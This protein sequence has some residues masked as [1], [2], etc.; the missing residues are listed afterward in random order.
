MTNSS[1]LWGHL[2]KKADF[3]SKEW[4]PPQSRFNTDK[5]TS[6]IKYGIGT[7]AFVFLLF[8]YNPFVKGLDV[9]LESLR[10][11]YKI[12]KEIT[13]VVVG[14]EQMFGYLQKYFPD[15]LPP[16]VKA[17]TPTEEVQKLYDLADCYVLA[18][19]NEG[20]S[21]AM[22]EAIYCG[23]PVIASDIPSLKRATT[24]SCVKFFES[25]E[26]ESLAAVMCETMGKSSKIKEETL[27]QKKYVLE[28]YSIDA[29]L[30]KIIGEYKIKQN[31]TN[32]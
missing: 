3:L 2:T 29:W 4:V 32:E 14:R 15:G 24:P 13:G 23:V 16:Y 28:K 20:F 22:I 8:A 1:I 17:I 27:K 12:N 6:R 7:N 9:F 10:H 30:N 5:E 25:G 11:I 18:S 26:P 19:R 21:Y 31:K